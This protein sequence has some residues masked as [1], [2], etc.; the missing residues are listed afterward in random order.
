[1]AIDAGATIHYLENLPIAA[2][3]RVYGAR[4]D[5]EAASSKNIQA[6][7]RSALQSVCETNAP[8]ARDIVFHNA[9]LFMP[10]SLLRDVSAMLDGS[11]PCPG[12]TL[13]LV[14]NSLATTDLNIVNLL[15]TWQLKALADHLAETGSTSQ[16]ARLRYFEY[17]PLAGV[18]LSLHSK[19]MVF[20]RDIFIGSAN[21]DVRSLMLDSNNGVLI[22]NA[23]VFSASYHQYLKTLLATPSR[24][25]ERTAG[26]GRDK[27][28]LS[29]EMNLQIDKLIERYAGERLTTQQQ[30]DIKLQVQSTSARVYELSRQI[31]RGDT[32][33]AD[34]FNELFKAI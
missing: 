23:P 19:V 14:T 32:R 3:G 28:A 11:R 10:A 16:S 33:A 1:M 25:A 22:S 6:T 7:W 26:I 9:Y 20:D 30:L 13:S 21:A 17:Q 15:A 31:M 18:Q 2:G 4:H 27:D 5:R 29:T 12:V 34:Q 8:A 24:V